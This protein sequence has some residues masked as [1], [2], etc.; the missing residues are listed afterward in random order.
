MAGF[1]GSRQGRLIV[2][3]V[4]VVAH[5]VLVGDGDRVEHGRCV[6]LN[7][8]RWRRGA[9]PRHATGG[10]RCDRRKAPPH[11]HEESS[12]GALA[13]SVRCTDTA[14]AGPGA[15]RPPASCSTTRRTDS[16]S[17]R[18]PT[19]ALLAL[20]GAM[21]S[22]AASAAR[23][24]APSRPRGGSLGASCDGA[25][26]FRCLRATPASADQAAEWHSPSS[27]LPCLAPRRP[28]LLSAWCDPGRLALDPKRHPRSSKGRGC[29]RVRWASGGARRSAA[30]ST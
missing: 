8:G 22:G 30:T 26:L 24:T 5:P 12:H 14:T 7:R 4:P 20:C 27:S 10:C 6:E 23:E 16:R 17:A 28:F 9:R 13:R 18:S 25:V 1:N 29:W 21:P 3:Q 11:A 2:E 15:G 19:R